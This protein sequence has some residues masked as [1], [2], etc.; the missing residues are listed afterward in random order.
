MISPRQ[1][2]SRMFARRD[3]DSARHEPEFAA[4]LE[5]IAVPVPPD[6]PPTPAAPLLVL[7]AAQ[8][9]ARFL[10][11]L[12]DED[13]LTGEILARDL[14]E[15]HGEMCLDLGLEQVRWDRVSKHFRQ[16]VGDRKHY[17]WHRDWPDS[18]PARLCVVSV[19]ARIPWAELPMAEPMRIAA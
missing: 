5:L 10:D 19:P 7:D 13:G 2:L 12:Q 18:K 11:W 1:V 6:V 17:V 4:P 14:A 3:T 15:M 16:L 9:A 8:H